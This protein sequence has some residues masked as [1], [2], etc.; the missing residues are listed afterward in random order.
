VEVKNIRWPHGFRNAQ[1]SIPLKRF[2]FVA[3]VLQISLKL[4]NCFMKCFLITMFFFCCAIAAYS[5]TGNTPKNQAQQKNETLPDA[6]ANT[7]GKDKAT[8]SAAASRKGPAISV[9]PTLFLWVL[10]VNSPNP[11]VKE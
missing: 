2:R 9:V 3:I 6:A 11:F 5:Q 7:T 1:K 10:P 4:K 8:V